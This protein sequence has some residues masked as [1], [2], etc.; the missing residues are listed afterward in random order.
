MRAAEN[1]GKRE[2]G[3]GT[4]GDFERRFHITATSVVSSPDCAILVIMKTLVILS[5]CALAATTFGQNV[6]ELLNEGQRAYVR[7]DMATA[8]EKFEMV[9]KIEPDNRTAINHIRLIMAAE[10]K[11]AREKGPGNATEGALKGVIMP[12]VKFTDSS[13]AE[14]LEFLRQKGNQAANGK[15]SINFVMQLDEATKAKKITLSLQNVPFTEVLRYIG[16][17]AEVQFVYDR[18]A[19]VV[20]PKG[21]APAAQPAAT[22]PPQQGVKIE[23]L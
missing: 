4:L 6:T 7:G 20:K 9:R 14:A 8:R 11:E 23:G 1:A 5:L 10:L 16:D 15:A 13:L 3:K 18:F 17:L 19:I 2:R 22:T 21:P 12:A